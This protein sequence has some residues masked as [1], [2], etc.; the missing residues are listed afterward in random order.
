MPAARAAAGG[1]SG[2][3]R[4]KPARAARR[5]APKPP[6]LAVSGSLKGPYSAAARSP[7]AHYP[8]QFRPQIVLRHTLHPTIETRT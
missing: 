6:A 8:F 4:V 7:H 5:L 2:I 1:V 3:R